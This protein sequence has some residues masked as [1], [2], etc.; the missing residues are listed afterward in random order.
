M[1]CPYCE[2]EMAEGNRAY[3]CEEC[4][5]RWVPHNLHTF[6]KSKEKQRR[7]FKRKRAYDRLPL[8]TKLKIQVG[9]EDLEDHVDGTQS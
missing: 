2:S 4:N 3:N 9:L 7:R 5:V 8:L 1:K 6:R